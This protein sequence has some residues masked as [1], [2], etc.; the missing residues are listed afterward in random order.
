MENECTTVILL[1]FS[2][3]LKLLH[4]H[5]SFLD[6]GSD[7]VAVYE[8]ANLDHPDD[9]KKKQQLKASILAV[10]TEIRIS[11]FLQIRGLDAN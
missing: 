6:H 2:L 8:K 9:K 4:F 1:L 5:S 7:F 3:Q 11:P 10:S